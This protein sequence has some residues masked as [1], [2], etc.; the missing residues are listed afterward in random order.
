M[1]D[2]RTQAE[3]ILCARL[4]GVAK[5]HADARVAGEAWEAAVAEIREL[6]A[7]RADL[8][9]EEVGLLEG[10]HRG[11]LGES[12]AFTA[13][14]LLRDAGADPELIPEWVAE[15]RRRREERRRLPFSG[16]PFAGRRRPG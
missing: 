1:I 10:A 7:G 5:R 15:G 13:A 2:G 3:R 8:L 6:A 14:A 9:A 12:F 16:G 4:S 11:E